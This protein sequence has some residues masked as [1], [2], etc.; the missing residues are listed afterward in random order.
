M[1]AKKEKVLDAATLLFFRDGIQNTSMEQIA[2]EAPVSKM[3]V[4]NYFKSKEGLVEQILQRITDK[5]MADFRRM[6][7]EAGGPLEALLGASSHEGLDAMSPVFIQ[8]LLT[9]YP[10]LAQKLLAYQKN[11]LTPEI[12]RLIFKGQQLGQIRKDISPH[13]LM[14]FMTGLKEFFSKPEIFAEV[15]DVKATSDQV[16]GILLYGIAAKDYQPKPNGSRP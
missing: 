15:Q 7:E 5:A 6:A 12:E 1:S 8:D 16:M 10:E 4:Y 3:T 14:L 11:V 13:V 9:G 2:E